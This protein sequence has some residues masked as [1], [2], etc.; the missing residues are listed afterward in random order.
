MTIQHTNHYPVEGVGLGLR[1]KFFDEILNTPDFAVDFM[2]MAPE[3]WL[4]FGGRQGRQLRTLTERFP[5]VCHGLS[6][7]LGGIRPLDENYLYALKAFF[8][9]HQIRAYTEHLS[10]CGD[11]G[12]LYDLMPIPFTEEAV[13][14]VSQRIQRV[15]DI[16]EQK[17]GIENVS[18]YAMPSSQMS[19]QEFVT[20]VLEEADCNLLFDVNN[21][22][23]NSINHQ[24]SA[25][26]YM[27]AMPTERMLYFHMAGHFDEAD[28]LKIDTHGQPV[29]AEVWQLLEQTYQFHGVVPTLLERD[30]NI[31]PLGELL[32]ELE[33]IRAYQKARNQAYVN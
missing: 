11:S 19:E 28:D 24:Y 5:F 8:E 13:H 15:Q 33:L 18:F 29:K 27:Q 22:Y 7:D 9:Q 14:Y 32:Q 17:I 10:Y 21:T 1:R 4:H 2:E 26:D 31:P 30:F 25:Q 12:H 16:L 23:V 20:A 3:N 6:L